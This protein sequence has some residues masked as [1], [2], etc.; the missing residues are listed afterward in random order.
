MTFLISEDEALKNLLKG[1]TVTDQKSGSSRNVGVWFGQP[2]QEVT[3]QKYP[4]ITIDMI[5]ISEDF[6]RSMRSEEHT[7]ELQSH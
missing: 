7:S 5:D 4:Y 1:M 6:M 3:D 2:D